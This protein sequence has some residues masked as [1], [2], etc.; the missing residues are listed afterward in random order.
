MIYAVEIFYN[1]FETIT[2]VKTFKELKLR[3]DQSKE[4]LNESLNKSRIS[5]DR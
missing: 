2:Y 1:D 5:N 3:Y 4:K